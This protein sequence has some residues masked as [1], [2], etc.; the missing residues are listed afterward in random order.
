MNILVVGGSGYVGGTL[1]DLL[2]MTKQ[3][4]F[5]KALVT[6]GAGFI[7]SNVVRLLL[8]EG[9]EVVVLDNLFPGYRSNSAPFPEVRFVEG[10]VRDGRVSAHSGVNG[11]AR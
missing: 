11:L 10:D 6:G 1:T 9:H 4:S 2:D 8:G 3:R 5:M 7:G